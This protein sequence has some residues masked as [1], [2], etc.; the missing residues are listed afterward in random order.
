[1]DNLWQREA[2]REMSRR[3]TTPLL[4]LK[5]ANATT[6]SSPKITRLPPSASQSKHPLPRT[7]IPSDKELP[8]LPVSESEAL[9]ARRQQSLD[10]PSRSSRKSSISTPDQTPRSHQRSVPIESLLKAS[11]EAATS[12]TRLENLG[13]RDQKA[14][15]R[16][17]DKHSVYDKMPAH[18]QKKIAISA[19]ALEDSLPYYF[20]RKRKD[21]GVR[22]REQ[23]EVMA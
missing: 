8:P 17:T 4:P 12:G 15:R 5:L 3:F 21:L 6:S 23:P 22:F 14:D 9:G 1:M 11:R 2:E 13:N 10:G 7:I 19:A 16:A 18:M 20:G